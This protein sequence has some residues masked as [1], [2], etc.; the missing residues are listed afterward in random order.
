MSLH[1]LARS[2][3]G[4]SHPEALAGCGSFVYSLLLFIL[5]LVFA[6]GGTGRLHMLTGP[7]VPRQQ[8]WVSGPQPR[9]PVC[10]SDSCAA[11]C[12]LPPLDKSRPRLHPSSC[13]AEWPSSPPP[14]GELSWNCSDWAG[15]KHPS[16]MINRQ[17]GAGGSWGRIPA[18]G[19]AIRSLLGLQ[20]P[21]KSAISSWIYFSKACRSF[22]VPGPCVSL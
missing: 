22:S 7:H 17:A 18:L 2:M 20:S 6:K 3:A 5:F 11:H 15:R 8:E 21:N 13:K 9:V 16:L 1:G 10:T 4:L 19:H 12:H 14:A